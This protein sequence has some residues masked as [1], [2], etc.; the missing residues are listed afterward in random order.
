MTRLDLF[1]EE[2]TGQVRVN[3]FRKRFAVEVDPTM[4][5][6]R[7]ANNRVDTCP[8]KRIG[9]FFGVE[10]RAN[11][12]K[13]FAGMKIKKNL[14]GGYLNH[15]NFFLLPDHRG[16]AGRRVSSIYGDGRTIQ[17]RIRVRGWSA[18]AITIGLLIVCESF[19]KR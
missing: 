8:V 10:C 1:F 15:R 18:T 11:P 16:A 14:T 5:T 4:M 13:M 3:T 19:G 9:E 12:Y 6:A 2:V 17:R 7:E